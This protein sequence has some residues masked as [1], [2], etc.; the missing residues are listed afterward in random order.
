[1]SSMEANLRWV[2]M[3]AVAPV[4]WGATYFVTREFLPHGYPLWGGV[5]RALPAGLL[6]MMIRRRLPA[7]SWWW[8][9]MVLGVLNMGA[10]F[11]LVYVAAQLLPASLASTIMATSSMAIM[12]AAWAV[13]AERPR[14][15]AVVGAALGIAGVCL[16]LLTG[17]VPTNPL[18]V[19][20]SVSAMTMSSVGYVL[21]KKWSRAAGADV[22]S[23]TSWQLIG[24]G[25]VLVPIAIVVEGAPPAIDGRALAGFGFVSL[26]A[27]A[28]AFAC[29][30]GGLRRLPAGVVGLVGLLNPV[31]GVLLGSLIAGDSLNGR[32]IA[33]IVLVLTGVLIG[34]PVIAARLRDRL[35]ARRQASLRIG[36]PHVRA[37]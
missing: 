4:A 12:L 10:F 26:V 20:A 8:R 33:G 32:Q 25:L 9:S 21:A 14:A 27:T 35:P 18:G 7:A 11:A 6:L 3:T 28:L 13:L 36:E 16:M 31:T 22:L 30:F 17:A 37:E 23:M 1:M 29:W 34:Q 24:G 15:V 19:L 2:L 5:I